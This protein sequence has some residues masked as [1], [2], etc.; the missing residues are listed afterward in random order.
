MIA[1][2]LLIIISGEPGTL[3]DQS[4]KSYSLQDLN[5]QVVVLDFAASWCAPCHKVLPHMQALS[6]EFP[7]LRVI[8]VSVDNKEENYRSL[9]KRHQLT[10]PVLWDRD[11]SWIAKF[12]PPAMPTTMVLD[13]TGSILYQHSGYSDTSWQAL[14]KAVRAAITTD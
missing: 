6:E 4:G 10:V 11:Q 2:L 9:I 13:G 3:Q 14:K 5:N 7:A 12:D 8:V 1:L